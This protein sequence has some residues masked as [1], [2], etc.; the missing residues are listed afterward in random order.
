MDTMK[1][2]KTNVCVFIENEL[3]LQESRELLE[4]YKCE[5]TEDGTFSLSHETEANYLQLFCVNWFLGFCDN[6]KQ[7]TLT[8]LETI[9]KDEH[10]KSLHS[11]KRRNG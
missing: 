1:L 11:K 3:Q 8:E 9:L 4:R 7:I 6:L 10:E 5:I 2:D